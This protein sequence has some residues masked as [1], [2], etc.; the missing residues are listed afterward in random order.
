M[1]WLVYTWF[2]YQGITRIAAFTNELEARRTANNEGYPTLVVGMEE[3]E[4]L[5]P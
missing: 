1:I 3:G 4:W 2:P 5:E